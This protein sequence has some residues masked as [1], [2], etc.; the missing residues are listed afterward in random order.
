MVLVIIIFKLLLF[1][2]NKINQLIQ[3]IFFIFFLKKIS[4]KIT[5]QRIEIFHISFSPSLDISK[6]DNG[7]RKE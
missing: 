5:H 4:F 7:Q 2:F 3:A 6:Y 1:I